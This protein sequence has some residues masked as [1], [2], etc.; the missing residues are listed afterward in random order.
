M[1]TKLLNHIF[2]QVEIYEHH[3]MPLVLS[4]NGEFPKMGHTLRIT[5]AEM[6]M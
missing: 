5:G 4:V 6:K 1:P 3:V 2:K